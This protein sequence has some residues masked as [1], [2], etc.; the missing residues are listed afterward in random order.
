[1]GHWLVRIA[2]WQFLSAQSLLKHA[3]V[4]SWSLNFDCIC[5]EWSGQS[6]TS[7]APCNGHGEQR[8]G[9]RKELGSAVLRSSSELHTFY[10]HGACWLYSD[11][12]YLYFQHRLALFPSSREG[13]GRSQLATACT[14]PYPNFDHLVCAVPLKPS[15]ETETHF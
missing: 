10:L 7:P 9:M 1:M 12:R 11:D 8:A 15:I 4:Q 5:E 3:C 13:R 14:I 2:N 6:W